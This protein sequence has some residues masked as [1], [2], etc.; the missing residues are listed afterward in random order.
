VSPW[1]S[2]IGLPPSLSSSELTCV[3][4][5][6]TAFRALDIHEFERILL[7]REDFENIQ[8]KGFKVDR[9]FFEVARSY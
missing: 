8:Y 1:Y 5:S 6:R 7:E 2:A 4:Y 3:C 9:R